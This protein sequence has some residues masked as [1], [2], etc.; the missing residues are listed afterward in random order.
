M[1]NKKEMQFYPD[2]PKVLYR[3]YQG[4]PIYEGDEYVEFAGNK[5]LLTDTE[6][7][8]RKY[9]FSEVMIAGGFDE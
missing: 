4:E 2:E 3:D 8:A 7:Y 6:Y 5:I 9:L 1:Y